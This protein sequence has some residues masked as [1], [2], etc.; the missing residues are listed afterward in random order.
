M[1]VALDPD[2]WKSMQQGHGG[3]NDLMAT[4]SYTYNS[5]FHTERERGGG[6][7]GLGFPPEFSLI[8]VHVHVHVYAIHV[9]VYTY[10]NSKTS[11]SA[12]HWVNWCHPAH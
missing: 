4:V 10:Y 7:R 8:H 3:W 9:H 11:P 1:K 5:G 6:G 2:I 12:V